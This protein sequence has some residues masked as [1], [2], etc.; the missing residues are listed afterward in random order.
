MLDV[1]LVEDNPAD[2]ELTIHALQ[3][4]G[5][6]SKVHH[7][8]DGVEALDFLFCR[9]PYASRSFANPP[10]VVLLD[11]KLPKLNGCEVLRELKEDPRTRSIPVIIL[12]SS[13]EERDLVQSYHLGVNSYIQ[14]PVSFVEFQEVVRQLG[15][16]WFG[17]NSAPPASSFSLG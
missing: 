1:L 2:A 10:R 7:L 17:V 4:S 8:W 13:K 14:K 11:L 15:L 9:G 6:M 12:T 16:Y 5:A 3:K